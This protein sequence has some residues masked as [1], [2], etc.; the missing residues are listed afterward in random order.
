MFPAQ[1]LIPIHRGEMA[2]PIALK[3]FFGI[4]G[5]FMPKK[6]WKLWITSLELFLSGPS[7]IKE[8]KTSPTVFHKIDKS[9]TGTLG[10]A[11][12]LFGMIEVQVEDDA[13]PMASCPG[14]TLTKHR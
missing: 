5:E 12:S 8:V 6:I 11:D 1:Y 10:V 4:I 3:P 14:H 13:S 9:S 7:V 2:I